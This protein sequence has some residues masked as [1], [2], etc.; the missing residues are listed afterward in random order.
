MRICSDFAGFSL[1]E[2]DV[3]RKA[4][5]K[6]KADVM[7][8][9]KQQF[10]D[11]A[12]AKGHDTEIAETIFGWIDKFSGYG[13]NR[14][15]G[16]AYAFISYRT[17]YAKAHYPL[18]F[19]EAMLTNSQGKQDSL[20]EIQELVHEARLFGLAIEPPSLDDVNTDFTI[21]KKRSIAFGLAHIKGIGQGA[22]ASVER[23]AG[24]AKNADE[25]LLHAFGACSCCTKKKLRSDVA[26]ALIKSGSCDCYGRERIKLL[27]EYK[28]LGILTAR[29]CKWIFD[30]I[31]EGS[32]SVKEAFL[33]LLDSKVPN[34]SRRPRI[35]EQVEEMNRSLAGNPKRMRI[36]YE[37]YLLGIP[38]SGSLVELYYN[39]R[40]NIKCKDF[41]SLSEGT[42]GYL[43]V[44]I[45]KVREIKDKNG[46][47]MCFLSISDETY[48]MDSAV[49]FSSFYNKV[50]WIIEE[51]KPVLIKGRKNRGSL[52]VQDISHL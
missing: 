35:I 47:L 13:F 48:M 18:E 43:G 33:A 36:A 14:S 9:V 21:T 16:V 5:G 6:K 12:K 4:I 24:L 15:H 22:I 41:H 17:A 38:L 23:I 8:K 20:E 27:A 42:N 26:E 44:V 34:K 29:E 19:F 32:T 3:A 51:G 45:E 28:L 10:L 11:G 31:N 2:A 7:A 25:F 39:E 40:V 37:K 30:N 1:K 52:V 49:V 46:N 50:S